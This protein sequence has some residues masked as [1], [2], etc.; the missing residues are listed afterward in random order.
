MRDRTIITEPGAETQGQEGAKV[1]LVIDDDEAVRTVVR[2]FLERGGYAVIEAAGGRQALAELSAGARVDLVITDLKMDDGSGGWLL[3]QVGYER[4]ELL[5]RTLVISGDAGSA[6]AA[7]L[8]ARWRCP[9]LA[10]PFT[11]ADLMASV[12]RLFTQ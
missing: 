1:A 4:P 6:A 2:R 7:H 11:Y 3:A 12:K 5:H 8:V 10:K 9:L